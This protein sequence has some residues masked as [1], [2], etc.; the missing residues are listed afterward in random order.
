MFLR[1]RSLARQFPRGTALLLLALLLLAW[2]ASGKD[3]L[4]WQQDKNT[5]SAESSTWDLNQ[6]LENV[7][8][9]T[10]WK[11][12]V[13]P[14]TKRTISTKFRQRTPGDALKLLLGDLSFA[15]LPQK[16]EPSKLYVFRT[17]VGEAT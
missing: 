11:V 4:V 15:L 3:S 10:G 7:A 6:L 5:V 13:E 8:E 12:Y 14:D 17:S 9:A 1:L 2:P 16:N